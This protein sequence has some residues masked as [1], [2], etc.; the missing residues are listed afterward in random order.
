MRHYMTVGCPIEAG[1]T[2]SKGNPGLIVEK[3]CGEQFFLPQSLAQLWTKLLICDTCENQ[4]AELKL[5]NDSGLLIVADTPF[6]LIHQLS[7]MRP[8]RH[9]VG[10]TAIDTDNK[11][12]FCVSLGEDKF[13]L[14]VVQKILWSM[15]DGSKKI[16][17]IVDIMRNKNIDVNEQNLYKSI[18]GLINCGA[19]YLRR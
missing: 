7:Q 12:I 11:K 6:S 1:V 10:L 5:L 16:E 3:C 17:D 14:D 4:Q 2:D 13:S 19:V 15:S 8:I 18:R 9:G